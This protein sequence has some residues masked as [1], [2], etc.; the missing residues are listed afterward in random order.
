MARAS[1]GAAVSTVWTC[2]AARRAKLGKYNERMAEPLL[3]AQISD[4]HIR[5]PGER[6]QGRVDT[7]A[8]LARCVA[9]ILSLRQPPHAVIA[10]GDLVD[11]ARPDAYERLRELLSPLA[12]PVYLMPGNHDDRAMMRSAFPARVG[13]GAGSPFVQ[14]AVEDLPLRLVLLDSVEEGRDEGRLCEERLRWLD[15][16]LSAAPAKPTLVFIHHPPFTTLVDGMDRIGLVH[17]RAV[18]AATLGRHPQVEAL[19]CGHVHRPIVTRF[20]GTIAVTAPSVAHQ[21]ALDFRRGEPARFTF[22]PPA[23]LL[24]AWTPDSGVVTHTVY[25][26]DASGPYDFDA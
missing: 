19:L 10:S 2:R 14:Y 22:E 4:L 17:G 16:T 11:V 21:I 5:P 15:E 20:A 12:M 18:L 1:M 8:M 26:D 9:K 24:H 25:C 6:V 7:A 23:F 13:S 3:I